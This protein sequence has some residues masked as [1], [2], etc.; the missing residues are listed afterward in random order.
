MCVADSVAPA[1][2]ARLEKLLLEGGEFLKQNRV[3][4]AREMFS[5]ALAVAP[6]N[7]KALGLLGLVCFRMNDFASAQPVYEH[8]VSIN[9]NDASLALNLGLVYLKLGKA[10]KAIKELQR[11]R[12]LDPSQTRAVSYLGLAY[13][14]NGAYAEA[15]QSFLQA[16]DEDLAREMEQYLSD[17]QRQRIRDSVTNPQQAAPNSS[18]TAKATP[19]QATP[20]QATPAQVKPPKATPPQAQPQPVQAESTSPKTLADKQVEDSELIQFSPAGTVELSADELEVIEDDD[21]HKSAT[22]P[23]SPPATPR[24]TT[25]PS[26]SGRIRAKGPG[27]I[28]QAVA[29]VKPSSAAKAGAT[30][31]AVGHRAPQPLF[32]FATDKLIRPDDGDH[33]FELSP[34]GVL[35]IRV[36]G[37][38]YTRTEGV[39]VTGGELAYEVASRRVRGASTGE[40][41]SGDGRHLFA[42]SGKGHL[43]ASPLA[44]RFTSVVLDEDILYLR[45]DLV[46]A[47][48]EQL[49]WE[50]GRVPGSRSTTIS[51]VQF[52]GQGSV[53][54]RS[55]RP[56]LAIKLAPE[57]VLHVDAHVLAGWIGRVIPRTVTP[58][59]G[60][61]TST[62]FVECSGEGVILV[63]DDSGNS[64]DNAQDGARP[65]LAG[66]K[67]IGSAQSS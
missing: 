35:I 32:E 50:N 59:A 61:E 8:L 4:E 51:M 41:F 45:E 57:K 67:W 37:R 42:V 25:N 43:I 24:V 9:R 53:T 1:D 6:N 12:D 63:E 58:A 52:R 22:P 44:E 54:F 26:A 11:C 65:I 28:S 34:G 66:A 40:D 39:N 16:G 10:A 31:L 33:P 47:F 14:R 18:G 20:P 64:T 55:K 48:E 46:F 19:P 29:L 49:R 7:A 5:Q 13:A 23:V 2:P 36:N 30:R 27:A 38:V 3:K 56:L 60:G 62:L 17:E 21:S 15:F